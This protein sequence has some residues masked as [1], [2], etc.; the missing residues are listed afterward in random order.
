MLDHD[1][2]VI[3]TDESLIADADTGSKSENGDKKIKIKLKRKK[4][5][6]STV[7]NMCHLII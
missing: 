4:V 7:N 2:S 3:E 1:Q 5:S 6:I